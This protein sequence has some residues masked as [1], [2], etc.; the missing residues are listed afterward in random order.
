MWRCA[1]APDCEFVEYPPQRL[2]SPL[3]TLEAL[4]LST[5]R[6]SPNSALAAARARSRSAR[7]A[8]CWQVAP[9]RGAAE[10]VHCCG[11]VARVLTLAGCPVPPQPAA[12]EPQQATQT[13]TQTQAQQQQRVPHSSAVLGFRQYKQARRALEDAK[14][15]VGLDLLAKDGAIPAPVLAAVRC[16]QLAGD[17]Q[18]V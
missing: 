7:P 10:V 9:A 16:Y 4:T 12:E 18:L 3:L 8:A 6:V 1:K 17:S 15:R 14:R 11:G 13:Q 2:L 5:F